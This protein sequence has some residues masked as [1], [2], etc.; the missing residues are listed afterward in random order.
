MVKGRKRVGTSPTVDKESGNI[1]EMGHSNPWANLSQGED[2]V[3]A[4]E[5]KQGMRSE[6]L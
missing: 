1:L 6:N 4:K 5:K 2:G 3:K